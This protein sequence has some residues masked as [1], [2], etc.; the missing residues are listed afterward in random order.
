MWF[1]FETD[2]NRMVALSA[3]KAV[4]L[5]KDHPRS[6]AY[7]APGRKLLK[8]SDWRSTPMDLQRRLPMELQERVD[9]KHLQ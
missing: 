5:P 9:C 7:H 4:R 8:R 3:E 1:G 6:L 2:I